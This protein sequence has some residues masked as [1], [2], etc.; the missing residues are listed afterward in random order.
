MCARHFDSCPTGT[1]AGAAAEPG[2]DG[3]TGVEL[4]NQCM[5]TESTVGKRA[6]ARFVE[7]LGEAAPR[8]ATGSIA[9]SLAIVSFR[10]WPRRGL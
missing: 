5:P 1:H 4:G 6:R 7:P 8:A 9:V 3:A 10:N 2:R